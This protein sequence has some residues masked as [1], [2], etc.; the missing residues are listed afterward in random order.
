MADENRYIKINGTALKSPLVLASMA[1]LTD[2][3]YVLERKSNV[4]AAFIGGYNTDEASKKASEE[5][6]KCGRKEFSAD[7]DEI[8]AELN[9][10]KNTDIIVGLNLRGSS[11][12]SFLSAAQRFGKKI[13]YEIDAH[14]RQEPMKKAQCGE[15]LLE[16]PEKLYEIVKALSAKGYTVSVKTRAGVTN[17][18]VLAKELWKAGAKIIHVDLMDAGYSKVRQIRN[19]CPLIIIANNGVTNPDKMMDYFSHG[20]DLVS[21]ARGANAENLTGLNRF[22]RATADSVG[23]YNAPKQLCRGGDLRSLAFCCMPV[24]QCP[25]LP[26]LDSIDMPRE[27]YLKL[28]QKSAAGT[29]L[30]EGSHTCFGSLAFCC[31]TSTPCM[32]RD[33]TLSSIKLEKNEYMKLKHQLSEKIMEQIFKNA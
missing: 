24:K 20:A 10:L 23:W 29:P 2:A 18:K 16:N 22:I 31:K 33:M 26:A 4:G 6:E 7:F 28:K 25:L 27:F 14:C 9:K 30:A 12:E 21:L 32:F 8:E 13:I 5:I 1:G 3:D 19:S 11:P 15:Y 17:D